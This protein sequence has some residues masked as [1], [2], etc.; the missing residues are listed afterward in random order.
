MDGSSRDAFERI[1]KDR[2]MEI[3]ED[4]ELV[5]GDDD[6][7]ELE[8]VDDRCLSNDVVAGTGNGRHPENRRDGQMEG[9]GEV[10]ID[11]EVLGGRSN[12]QEK[13]EIDHVDLKSTKPVGGGAVSCE[14]M[15]T[16]V[17]GIE[18]IVERESGTDPALHRP[19]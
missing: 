17:K 18:T 13:E 9:D 11:P 5:A 6:E 10:V 14:V 2:I 16:R 19:V 7:V 8:R 12:Y 3:Q 1:D 4:A 15:E